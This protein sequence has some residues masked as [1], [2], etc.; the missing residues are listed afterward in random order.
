MSVLKYPFRRCPLVHLHLL[1]ISFPLSP[2]LSM[3]DGSILTPICLPIRSILSVPQEP[4]HPW[5]SRLVYPRDSD[6]LVLTHVDYSSYRCIPE[7]LLS[8]RYFDG[9]P[10]P[11]EAVVLVLSCHKS[12][13][14]FGRHLIDITPYLRVTGLF[15][16]RR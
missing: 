1:L 11:T 9:R 2:R 5:V 6:G 15:S 16:L 8:F 14:E 10:C 12:W 3:D 4:P 7:P 13:V